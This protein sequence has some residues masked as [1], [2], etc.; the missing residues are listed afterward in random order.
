MEEAEMPKDAVAP[1]GSLING[2]KAKGNPCP[3]EEK[4]DL[5]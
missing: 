4:D 5:D 2:E 1:N 3:D